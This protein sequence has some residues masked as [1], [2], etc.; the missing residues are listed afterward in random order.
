MKNV[1]A[2]IARASVPI[3]FCLLN[4]FLFRRGGGSGNDMIGGPLPLW[5]SVQGYAVALFAAN[6]MIMAAGFCL[7]RASDPIDEGKQ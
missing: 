5:I 4:L 2:F 3:Y 6:I 1:P 7:I